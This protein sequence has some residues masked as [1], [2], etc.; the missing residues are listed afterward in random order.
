LQCWYEAAGKQEPEA[1]RVALDG[2]R[3]ED[4]EQDGDGEQSSP[5]SAQEGA[6][7]IAARM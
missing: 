4:P 1:E 2:L 6:R 3:D 5:R 7:R